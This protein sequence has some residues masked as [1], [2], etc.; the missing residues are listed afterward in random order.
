MDDVPEGYGVIAARLRTAPATCAAERC[1][2]AGKRIWRERPSDM[3][4]KSAPPIGAGDRLKRW[5]LNASL[6][7]SSF[8][9]FRNDGVLHRA[10]LLNTTVASGGFW[11]I[12]VARSHSAM[13]SPGAGGLPTAPDS[14]NMRTGRRLERVRPATSRH[15]NLSTNSEHDFRLGGY[16]VPIVFR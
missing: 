14:A 11:Q 3:S 7:P 5:T 16:G 4:M 6:S 9:I 15:G 12:V 2:H 13:T 10:S 1:W 8:R